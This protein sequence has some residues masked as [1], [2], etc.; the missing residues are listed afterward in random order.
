MEEAGIDIC[1]T[2][3]VNKPVFTEKTN[4]E[5]NAELEQLEIARVLNH[6]GARQEE[7]VAREIVREFEHRKELL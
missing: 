1:V 3:K 4:E 2:T 5:L 6:I 7:S